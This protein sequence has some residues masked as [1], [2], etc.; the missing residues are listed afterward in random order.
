[1]QRGNYNIMLQKSICTPFAVS[2][3]RYISLKLM[4]R[5]GNHSVADPLQAQLLEDL[6]DALEDS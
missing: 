2:T 1:M 5:F 3:V 4:L 6:N